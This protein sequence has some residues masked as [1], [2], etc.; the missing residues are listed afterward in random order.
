ME[1]LFNGR[2]KE[3]KRKH[4]DDQ[5]HVIVVDKPGCNETVIMFPVTDHVGVHHETAQNILVAQ[6]VQ[7]DQYSNSDNGVSYGHR[8]RWLIFLQYYIKLMC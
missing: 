2:T 4:I 3:V 1:N 5:V 6:R 8:I 7:T